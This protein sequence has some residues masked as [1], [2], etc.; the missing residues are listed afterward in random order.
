M[1]GTPRA[2]ATHAPADYMMVFVEDC[3]GAHAVVNARFG[4]KDELYEASRGLEGAEIGEEGNNLSVYCTLPGEPQ[5]VLDGPPDARAA[6][7]DRAGGDLLRGRGRLRG[8]ERGGGEPTPEGRGTSGAV[9]GWGGA[10]AATS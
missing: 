4:S 5:E 2:W 10:P 7:V 6:G 8:D 1:T 3:D 9:V